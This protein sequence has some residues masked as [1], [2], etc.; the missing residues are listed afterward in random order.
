MS[1]VSTTSAPR[2]RPIGVGIIG[3]N[4]NRG[5]A[6]WAHIPALQAL[7]EFDP[8]VEVVSVTV[9]VPYHEHLAE[10]ADVAGWSAPVAAGAAAGVDASPTGCSRA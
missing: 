9:K 1:S 10:V 8:A 7:D 5:W 6:Q 4:P 3:G 2:T